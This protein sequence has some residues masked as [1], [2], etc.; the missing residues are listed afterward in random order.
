MLLLLH[1]S[2]WLDFGSPLSRALMLVHLGLFLIWQ[3]IQRGDQ[4]IEWYNGIIFIGLT[5]AFVYWI[6]WWFMFVWMI[7]LI[8]MVGGRVVTSRIERY[9]YLLVMI[10]LVSELLIGCIPRLFS[11]SSSTIIYDWLKYAIPVLPLLLPLFPQSTSGKTSLSVDL[12]HAI[13][14]SLLASLLALGSLVL[15]YHSGIDYFS[16]LIQ[17]LFFIGIC[18]IAISWLLSP[19]AG[20]S[21]LSQLWS[22][23][24][25]NIGTP[26]EQWLDELSRLRQEH[27]SADNFLDSAI[28]K[29]VTLPWVAGV[30]WNVTEQPGVCGITTKHKINLTLNNKP[31]AIYTH[32][33]IGGALLLHCNL[34]IQLIENFYEAKINE[35]ELA[36]QVH[37][38]AIYETGARITHDIK[39]LL[40]SMHSMITIVQADSEVTD[41]KSMIIVKRQFPYFIQRLEL[42]MSKLQTPQQTDRDKIY[43]MDW[44]RE[45]KSH[46]KGFNIV[47]GSDIQDDL[48]IPF[49][50][51]NN[52]SE[53]LLE[54]A[55]AKRK[56]EPDIMISITATSNNNFSLMVCDT[57]S[58]ID[59]ATVNLL[60]KEPV[61]SDN[62]L[63]IGLY[64]AS[65]LAES[66]GY[67]LALKNNSPGKVCFELSRKNQGVQPGNF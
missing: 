26:F 67:S 27:K 31:L 36:L 40:Q 14:A 53:N 33:P 19:H 50:L 29:L 60:F 52:V 45:L 16:A 48:L 54:N 25:L 51:F 20:F 21:G 34:L 17:T 32:V 12:L 2:M 1:F 15:M 44:W 49:D 5:L 47:F 23:S 66:S 18:L 43:L 56:N 22:R 3:P 9:F 24:L 62:G 41:S 58:V 61:V 11:I 10:F 8:G 35:R 6:N 4:S 55:I 46:Y 63:G 37:L 42:A 7:M 30:E 38:Q 65:R 28:K 59:N 57:G 64:Q 13:T 39:N